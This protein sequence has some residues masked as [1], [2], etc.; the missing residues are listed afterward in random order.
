MSTKKTKPTISEQDV[1]GL[2]ELQDLER[3]VKKLKDRVKP[4][5]DAACDYYGNGA[6]I[7]RHGVKIEL[8]RIEATS[9]TWKSVALAVAPEEEI[10]KVQPMYT[11]E[12][13][14]RKAKAVR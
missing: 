5:M 1:G 13:I 11:V 8:S 2:L 14:T 9:T 6:V 4:T 7:T 3:K 12:R 10:A